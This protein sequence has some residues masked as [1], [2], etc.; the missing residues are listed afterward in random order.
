MTTGTAP[1]SVAQDAP[2]EAVPPNPPPVATPPAAAQSDDPAALKVKLELIQRDNAEKG[3]KNAAL[4]EQLAE[5]RK[6]LEDTNKRILS[7]KTQQLEEQGKYQ[8]L[9]ED[10]KQ[11]IQAREQRIL[12]LEG[13]LETERSSVAS[14]RLKSASLSM[15][16]RAEAISSEQMYGLLQTN[17]REKEGK[18]V[19]L[20]GGAEIPLDQY[21]TN[22]RAPGSGWEHHFSASGKSGMGTAPGAVSAVAPGVENPWVTGN[23]TNQL[24]LIAENPQLAQAMQAEASKG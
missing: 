22:L 1:G 3:Q 21:L 4:N 24:R 2:P 11:T 17:L 12:E 5:V 13:A 23:I 15:I 16:S 10:A 8:Q 18:P 7:G 9:W 20:S 6:Q 19:V 14:E